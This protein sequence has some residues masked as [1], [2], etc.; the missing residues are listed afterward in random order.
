[1]LSDAE[2][3]EGPVVVVLG[4]LTEAVSVPTGTVRVTSEPDAGV[5]V[6]TVT[7]APPPPT[8]VDTSVN[9]GTPG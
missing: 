9:A 4:W 5:M 1:V 8:G 2:T 3:K 7:L 6:T